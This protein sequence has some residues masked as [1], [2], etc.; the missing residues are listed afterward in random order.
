[1]PIRI[2]EN[3]A[4]ERI[5]KA[6]VVERAAIPRQSATSSLFRLRL[7]LL[8]ARG[9][10]QNALRSAIVIQLRRSERCRD[11]LYLRVVVQDEFSHLTPPT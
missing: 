5:F 1:M 2:P 9:V 3:S 11:G 6:K 4:P 7:L 10:Y 8:Q